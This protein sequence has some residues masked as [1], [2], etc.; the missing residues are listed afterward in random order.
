MTQPWSAEC[1]VSEALARSLIE[2]QFPRLAPVRVL[3]FGAGWD[4]TAFLVND[5]YVF[6]F[7]RRQV[8]VP[9]LE[10]ETRILPAITPLLPLPVPSPMFVGQPTAAFAWPF[11][12]YPLLP[13][14]TACVAN[15]NLEERCRAAEPLGNFLA[16]LHSAPI[17]E[18]ARRHSAGP[19][20]IDRLNMARAIPKARDLLDQLD[21]RGVLED[22][23][24]FTAI[25]D[26]ADAAYVPRTDVLVHG[27][28]YVRHLLVDDDK[29]LSGVIDWGDVHLGDPAL[30]FTIALT[31]LPPAARAAFCRAYGRIDDVAW[32][33]AQFRA[34]RHT[35]HV[36]DYAHAIG[37]VD[38][39]RESRLALR[40]LVSP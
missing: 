31:F 16:V 9:F 22:V 21:Q 39:L 13:G 14:R 8:V 7:P 36:L 30:D 33:V 23:R 2:T 1:V 29:R 5:A 4:N 34:L 19:D 32:R 15:L 27:D 3:P 35:L 20:R 6:R 26:A 10:T 24:P 12:G 11:A 25:I 18:T 17:A 37:D 28:L 38:L 40:H